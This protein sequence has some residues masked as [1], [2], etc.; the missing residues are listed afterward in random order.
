MTEILAAVDEQ[1]ANDL[2]DAAISS[3]GTQTSSGSESLGPFD[4]GYSASATIVNGDVDLIAPGTIRI[5]DLT[6]DWSVS[7]SF[8]IDLS[9][10]LPDFCIPQV[11]VDIPC[12]G[13]VC[14]PGFCVDWPTIPIPIPT[15]SDSASTTAD[16]GL[17]VTNTGTNWRVE[18]VIQGI[19][20]LQFGATTAALIGVITLAVSS[21]LLLVPFIG[22]FLAVAVAGI[23]AFI[24]V[25]G[26]FGFLGAILT[27]F[28]SGLK[29]KIYD[30]PVQF[31]VL[32][33]EGPVDPEVN[34]RL[35]VIAA[36]VQHNGAEDELVLFADI[37]P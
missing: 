32:P 14:T 7:L 18:V 13:E 26:L 23:M 37:S 22:P 15:L 28:V 6:V 9:D 35:D 3:I 19:P 12:V 2:L 30:Q 20:V 31:V 8:E 24:T 16:F 29:I 11:C 17:L 33:A 34:I 36:G 27:P 25:A 21:A 5:V 1:G 4:F 10:I